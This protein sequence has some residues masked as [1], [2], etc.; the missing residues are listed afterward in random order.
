MLHRRNSIGF[1]LCYIGSF[2]TYDSFNIPPSAH[3]TLCRSIL[4][5][6]RS[7]LTQQT[8]SNTA[9][10]HQYI[11][12]HTLQL[13][14]GYRQMHSKYLSL[15]LVIY[16][17][18]GGSHQT[19]H[20]KTP[21]VNHSRIFFGLTKA[22]QYRPAAGRPQGSTIVQSG[23]QKQRQQRNALIFPAL[24]LGYYF[25]VVE[26]MTYQFL[27]RLKNLYDYCWQRWFL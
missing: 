19:D 7:W 4:P 22:S 1:F 6:Q 13:G 27:Y 14:E 11:L 15:L 25:L 23:Q 12:K 8:L 24:V 3:S 20:R 5:R 9:L 16:P 2:D 21:W 18:R 10:Q 17:S 26:S